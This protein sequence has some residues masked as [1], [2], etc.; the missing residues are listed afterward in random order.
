MR[1]TKKQTDND[2]KQAWHLIV[3][4]AS[5]FVRT[6]NRNPIERVADA[7]ILASELEKRGHLDAF[8]KALKK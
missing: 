5:I 6:S 4:V 2:V 7:E 8:I 1:I 3:I